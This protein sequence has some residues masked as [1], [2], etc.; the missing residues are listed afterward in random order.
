MDKSTYGKSSVVKLENDNF[1]YSNDGL[2]IFTEK[3]LV[4]AQCLNKMLNE[5][6]RSSV[7]FM[8]QMTG[9]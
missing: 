2:I 3:Y 5:V 7:Y 6:S 4:H 8:V 9:L 1:Y